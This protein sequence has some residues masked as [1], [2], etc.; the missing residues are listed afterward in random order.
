[1]IESTEI[2]DDNALL[3]SQC[4]RD[5]GLRYDAEKLGAES[6]KVCPHCGETKGKKLSR[7]ILDELTYYFFVKGSVKFFE[8]GAAPLI[9]FNDT[10]DGDKIY[11]DE[12][13]LHHDACILQNTLNIKLF[14]YGPRLWMC[15]EV[16]PLKDLLNESTRS[17]KISEI[18]SLY[19]SYESTQNDK[20]FRLRKNPKDPSKHSSYDSPPEER[21]GLSRIA[22]KGFP[23]LCGS[24]DIECCIHECRVTIEDELYLAQLEPSKILRLLNLSFIPDEKATEFESLDMAVHMLFVAGQHAYP[25][26]QQ[27][28]ISAQQA[29]FDG[30]IYPSF[31]SRM[32]TGI[33]PFDTVYGI[34]VRRIPEYRSLLMVNTVQNIS[35]FGRPIADGSLK[36]KSINRLLL[37]K[38]TYNFHFGPHSC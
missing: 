24:P 30:I 22:S 12:M 5:F 38:A 14:Y 21:I 19:P 23:A 8:Y 33:F 27:I 18:F 35:I 37:E 6:D 4:F 32:R 29:G 9:Q 11:S 2:N 28:A 1:M 31:F 3:C 26:T 34:S 7:K 10:N 25:I 17:K 36:V 16:E 15:G 13:D 20:F